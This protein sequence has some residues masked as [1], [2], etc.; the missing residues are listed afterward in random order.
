MTNKTTAILSTMC[1][2]WAGLFLVQSSLIWLVGLLL[3][4]LA[5]YLLGYIK[6]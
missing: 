6:D 1:A 2:L 5:G 4:L 3:S